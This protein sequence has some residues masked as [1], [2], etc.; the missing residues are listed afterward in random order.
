[1]YTISMP[2]TQPRRYPLC[3]PM[4]QNISIPL[5]RAYKWALEPVDSSDIPLLVAK[6]E[7]FQE[8]VAD[9]GSIKEFARL[10][11]LLEAA[12]KLGIVGETPGNEPR[13]T[14]LIIAVDSYRGNWTKS[15]WYDAD[16]NQ[17]IA[18]TAT[19]EPLFE[20]A[21]AWRSLVDKHMTTTVDALDVADTKLF[22]SYWFEAQD[23]LYGQQ[24]ERPNFTR[25]GVPALSMTNS[26]TEPGCLLFD[27]LETGLGG[28]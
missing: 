12:K 24:P 2:E 10:Y 4:F 1:M 14:R 11:A 21:I 9:L 26:P 6:H 22:T 5:G 23:V 28:S 13:E 16:G 7:E 25:Y 3:K 8:A 20:H 17:E 15:D 27:R 19:S 18:F